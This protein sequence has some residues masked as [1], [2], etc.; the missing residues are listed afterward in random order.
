[1]LNTPLLD[2]RIGELK[3]LLLELK[4]KDN[5]DHVGLSLPLELLKVTQK[6]LR[7]DYKAFLNHNWSIAVTMETRDV[8]EDGHT[9][10]LAT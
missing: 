1:M 8:T 3:E 5:V 2:L 4:T 7:E 6:L 9:K 10:L